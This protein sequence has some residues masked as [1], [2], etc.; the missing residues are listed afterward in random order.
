MFTSDSAILAPPPQVAPAHGDELTRDAPVPRLPSGRTVAGASLAMAIAWWLGC[1]VRLEG[2]QSSTL[3]QLA[4]AALVFGLC[5]VVH[6][7]V[8][9]LV[10]KGALT[11]LLAFTHR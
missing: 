4:G 3:V 6:A 7:A 2:A 10:P 8:R 9:L 5:L 11:D 1:L